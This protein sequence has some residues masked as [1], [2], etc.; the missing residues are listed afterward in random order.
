MTKLDW[1]NVVCTVI[2]ILLHVVSLVLW[3]L[4]LVKLS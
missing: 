1:F 4:F 2:T 3:I